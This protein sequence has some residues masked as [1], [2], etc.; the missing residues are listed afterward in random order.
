MISSPA[1]IVVFAYNRPRHLT[2]LINS[3]ASNALSANSDLIVFCDG[4]RNTGDQKATAE[5]QAFVSRIKGFRSVESVFRRENLGLSTSVIQGVT[6]AFSKF[7]K[8]IFLEDDLFVS[9][10][11]L[12]FM[13]EALDYY[14]NDDRVISIHGY[15]YPTRRPLPATFFLRGA[16][17]WGWGTWKRGWELF[18]A[19]GADL[20]KTL[21]RRGLAEA[22]GRGHFQYLKMLKM[23]VSGRIDSW[24]I[25]WHAAAFL[26]GKLTLYPGQPLV[27]NFGND[28]SGTHC[29]QTSRF[30]VRLAAAAPHIGD[31][32][33]I[34]SRQALDAF[35]DF[36]KHNRPRLL[37]DLFGWVSR[38]RHFS[39]RVT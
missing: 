27:Q 13:N 7:G 26:N 3:L 22:F 24:A 9:P 15:C 33:V 8:A 10:Y 36:A 28:D 37:R 2:M 14:A 32:D 1:P 31:V 11:F 16:D 4:P 30:D 35:M 23:A 39:K 21:E 6:Y 19:D 20:L 17:C 12:R 29:A 18:N 38:H 5:V 25:R 34:E